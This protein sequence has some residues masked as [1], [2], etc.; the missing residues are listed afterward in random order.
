MAAKQGVTDTHIAELE[1][2]PPGLFSDKELA[3]FDL[4]E[5]IWT[6]AAAAGADATLQKRM[7]EHFTDAEMVEL[8]WGDRHV[9]R[10]GPDDR[11]FRYRT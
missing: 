10:P 2:R 11:F 9:H 6:N 4:A 8:V 1:E 3:A 7:R 5:A